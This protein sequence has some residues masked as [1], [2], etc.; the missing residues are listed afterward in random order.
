ML[1]PVTRRARSTRGARHL[2]VDSAAGLSRVHRAFVDV[3]VWRRTVDAALGRWLDEVARTCTLSFDERNVR[4]RDVK[5][6]RWLG[7]VEASPQ[8]QWCFTLVRGP[9]AA[10][11]RRQPSSAP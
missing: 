2:F 10:P 11:T 5:F 7:A 9:F 3:C 4:A 1:E 6:D 8:R